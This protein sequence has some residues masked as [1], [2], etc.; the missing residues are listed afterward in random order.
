M[1]NGLRGDATLLIPKMKEGGN[2]LGIC[3][4]EKLEKDKEM[5]YFGASLKKHNYTNIFILTQ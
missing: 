5:D 1:E 4:L 2:R 3:G